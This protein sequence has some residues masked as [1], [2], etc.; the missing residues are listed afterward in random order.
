MGQSVSES[1]IVREL[2]EM[3]C[4]RIARRVIRALQDMTGC[5][6]SGD[7]SCL[8]NVTNEL[9]SGNES[10]EGVAA[11]DTGNLG[12]MLTVGVRNLDKRSARRAQSLEPRNPTPRIPLPNQARRAG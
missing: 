3:I 1:A 6:Q 12:L 9:A 11:Q 4:R 8:K 5:R 10:E 2:A 7:D